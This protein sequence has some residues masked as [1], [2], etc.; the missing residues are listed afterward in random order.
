MSNPN[1]EPKWITPEAAKYAGCSH[2]TLEKLRQTGGGPVY[3][4]IGRSVLY[5]QSDLDAW[6]EQCR[7]TSTSDLGHF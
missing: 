1:H 2:R 6:L 7:R 5:R 3:L 4:K